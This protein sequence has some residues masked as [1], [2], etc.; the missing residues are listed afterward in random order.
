MPYNFSLNALVVDDAESMLG[1][2]SATLADLGLKSCTTTSSSLTALQW[3][4]D[5]KNN[6]HVV[7]I[8]LNMP[9]MDGIELINELDKINFPGGIVIISRLDQK[10]IDLAG[11]T[12]KNHRLHLI[13]CIS[14]PI[15]TEKTKPVLKKLE[16]IQTRIDNT[17]ASFALNEIKDA[18]KNDWLHPYYQ[19]IINNKSARVFALEVLA[20]ITKPG[21]ADAIPA[22]HFIA[23]AE[24]GG[25][26]QKITLTVLEKALDE[27]DILKTTMGSHLK[28]AIN[29]SPVLLYNSQLP[30]LL[31][32]LIS[33]KGF[34]VKDV[35]FEITENHAIDNNI[36]L[37]TLNRLRIKGFNLGL[38]DFGT[39]FTNIQ[40]LKNLPYT[41][42]KID[43]S[44]VYGIHQDKLSQ[45]IAN[46]LFDVFNELHVGIVAEGVET[47]A[48][49]NYLNSQSIPINLQGYIISKPKH[50]DNILRWHNSWQKLN[51]HRFSQ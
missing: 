49:L 7:F 12:T 25:L 46:S 18:I 42:I 10:I 16:T 1:V 3:L 39:G 19:P 35:I 5:T 24:A 31:S 37:E 40:Q 9:D 50:R 4:K 17:N 27:L 6:F 30:D 14:K 20:R 32:R 45:V 34:S 21:K 48:D 11:E 22:G 26:V 29:I 28:I 36:Q 51:Q 38:D 8:D 15:T 47:E 41:E 44:L 23:V 33:S 13:G 43:R 2:I